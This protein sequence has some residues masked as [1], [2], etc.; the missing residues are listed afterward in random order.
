AVGIKNVALFPEHVHDF[1]KQFFNNALK[2]FNQDEFEITVSQPSYFETSFKENFIKA[3]F[4]H[5]IRFPYKF[6]K[7]YPFIGGWEVIYHKI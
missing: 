7:N 3:L 5:I 6:N 4:S 1:S 2:T